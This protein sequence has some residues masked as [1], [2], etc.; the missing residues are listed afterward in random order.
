MKVVI[1]TCYGGFGLSPEAAE[2]LRHLNP[3][4]DVYNLEMRTDPDLV[5]LVEAWGDS[6]LRVVEVPDD[7][8][9]HIAEYDGYEW[10]AENHRTWG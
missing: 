7:V 3:D 10:I 5:K 6:E 8:E 9:W 2:Q 4:F 1:S